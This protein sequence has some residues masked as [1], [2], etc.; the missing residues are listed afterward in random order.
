M[1]TNMQEAVMEAMEAPAENPESDAAAESTQSTEALTEQLENFKQMVDN[2]PVNVMTCDPVDFKINYVNQTSIRT[3]KTLEH[4]L[5]IKADELLGQCI[6]IFHK[7]PAHQRKLLGDPRNLPHNAHIQVGDEIL[8]LLVSA[9]MDRDGNY[10]GPMLT[11]SII[12]NIVQMT[13][14][15]ERQVKGVV[16]TVSSASTELQAS[17]QEMT[18]IAER[19]SEQSSSVASP[20]SADP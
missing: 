17:A 15:F 16:Q 19:T 11:W 18:T 12:T 7:D 20:A 4:L 8:D 14:D 9:I 2:M 5:P 3:L 1:T 13:D 10:I 6:D